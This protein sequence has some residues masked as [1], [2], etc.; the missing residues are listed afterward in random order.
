MFCLCLAP[1]PFMEGDFP[2]RFSAPNREMSQMPNTALFITCS[3]VWWFTVP[4]SEFVS[5]VETDDP[6]CIWMG[7]HI[8]SV[9]S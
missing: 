3:P 4:L 5:W 9:G 7:I 1:N 6:A 2:S 8:T